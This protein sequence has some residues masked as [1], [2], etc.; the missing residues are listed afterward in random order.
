MSKVKYIRVST[1]EQNT[2]RQEV[3]AKEFSKI[4]IDKTSGSIQFTERKEASKLI[5]D[6]E[7]G[8]VSE[9]HISSIDRLGRSI[10]DILTM[11]EYFNQK[12]IRL[13]VENIG[14]FSLIDNKPNPSFKMIISVLGNVAEMERLN[15]LERQ[16]QGIEVAKAKGTYKGRLYG[17]RMTDDEILNKYKSV[18]RELKNGESL[19]RASKIGGCSLGTVQ[20]IQ[21]ILLS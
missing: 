20:K 14:M 18:V 17:T 21:K 15:M 1:L 10:I 11:V 9:I 19:R 4:Y 5:A 7:T 3:N 6:I 8:F 13:F 2:G 12:G 16:R